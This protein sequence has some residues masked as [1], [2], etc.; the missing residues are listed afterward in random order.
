VTPVDTTH[1]AT[2]VSVRG[3]L[4]GV[5]AGDDDGGDD[6]DGNLFGEGYL[7]NMW[8]RALA[9]VTVGGLVRDVEMRGPVTVEQVAEAAWCIRRAVM[10]LLKPEVLRGHLA[11][12]ARATDLE[13]VVAPGEG[14]KVAWPEVDTAV[15]RCIA[16]HHTGLDVS[17]GVGLGADVEF[18][19]PGVNGGEKTKPT[20]V[21][22][23]YVAN[24][25]SMNLVPR[26]GI[27]KGDRDWEIWLALRREDMKVVEEQG[28]LGAWLLRP[29]A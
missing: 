22:R 13:G 2:A 19:I 6:G 17:V 15:R 25:G 18:E 4:G 29:A 8:V 11:L 7:G 5:V 14:E 12:A 23:A 9:G 16:R 21:R 24:D 10:E 26:R 3:R 28:E 1:F 27:T 20:W